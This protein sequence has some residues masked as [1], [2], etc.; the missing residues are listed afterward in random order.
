MKDELFDKLT[1]S[2][3]EAGRIRRGKLKPSRVF[4]I[5]PKNDIVKVR[6]KLGLSQSE[7]AAVLGISQDTL[8]NWEQGR[9]QPTGPAKV[10]LRI[11]ARHPKILLQV[12]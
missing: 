5:D 11:A 7:F 2:I 4:R 3:R 1:K 8:Q 6:G 9:R 10:L 12:A